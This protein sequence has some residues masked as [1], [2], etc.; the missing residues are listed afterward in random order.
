MRALIGTVDI[1]WIT[2]DTLRYDV[3]ASEWA[4][5]GTPFL[6]DVIPEGWEPRHT[7]ASFTYAAH[8]AFFAGFLP[9]PIGPGPHLRQYALAFPGS[10]TIGP[11]TAVFDTPDVP[12]GLRVAGY[13]TACI[14]GTGFFNRAT[15]LGRVLPGLFDEAS[16]NPGFGVTHP[17]STRNQ[18]DA[19]LTILRAQDRVFLFVNLSAIHQPN[20]HY[21]PGAATDSLATH[22]AAL[23]YVDGQLARLFAGLR[24]PTA[25]VLM[26]DHGTCYGED[27]Y[28]G[29]R[30]GHPNVWTV[31]YAEG[32]WK[33]TSGR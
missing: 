13:H 18:V 24:R 15:P 11:E 14:G 8:A 31:P 33:P 22:A 17:D 32:L 1:L 19:A 2:L 9:T 23:R 29:H 28:V 30:L 6:R 7:P 12:A 4:P 25:W 16:W 10:E 21:L 5:G 26:S 20:R 27:G 3:A